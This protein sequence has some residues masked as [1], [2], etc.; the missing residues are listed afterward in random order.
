MKV[1]VKPSNSQTLKPSINHNDEMGVNGCE[2]MRIAKAALSAPPRNC[3]VGTSDEQAKRMDAYCASQG[4]RIG[5]SW[6]CE[7][8]PL[9]P[10]DRCELAWAQ[11]PYVEKEGG[12]K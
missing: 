2:A 12:N 6:R 11:M 1:K 4:E 3:D 7:N 9:C 10:I 5:V 8:C